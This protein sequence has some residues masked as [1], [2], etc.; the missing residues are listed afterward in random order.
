MLPVIV[1]P[2]VRAIAPE[3]SSFEGGQRAGESTEV[4]TLQSPSSAPTAVTVTS[5]PITKGPKT[6][7][8][9]A[10]T[11]VESPLFALTL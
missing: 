1:S 4:E 2:H 9:S 5:V 8:P 10:A 6:V 3:Q 7:D 11:V